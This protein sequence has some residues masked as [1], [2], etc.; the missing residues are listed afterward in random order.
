M[1]W[2]GLVWLG[3]VLFCLFFGFWLG[4]F[5]GFFLS[6][7]LCLLLFHCGFRL[8]YTAAL[9]A[10]TTIEIPTNKTAG[11]YKL[12]RDRINKTEILNCSILVSKQNKR[13]RWFVC[14]FF[15]CFLFVFFFVSLHV[16]KKLVD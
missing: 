14:L 1:V 4:V 6:F 2:F 15:F 7:F 10:T 8:N 11:I 13:R 5:W 9:L 16:R 3:L 12:V